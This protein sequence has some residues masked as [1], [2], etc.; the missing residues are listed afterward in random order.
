MPH[1]AQRLAVGWGGHVT[2]PW[3]V[4]GC[5]CGLGRRSAPRGD[6]VCR[7]AGRGSVPPTLG[8]TGRPCGTG[9][10]LTQC[11][12]GDKVSPWGWGGSAPVSGLTRGRCGAS[13]PAQGVTRGCCGAG[14]VLC[15]VR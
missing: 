7:G 2:P 10:G 15:A 3:R 1:R 12:G 11:L 14:S 9:T 4:T 5:H 13:P 6:K 8:V